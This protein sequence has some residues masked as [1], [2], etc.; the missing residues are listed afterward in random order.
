MPIT[1]AVHGVL[2]EGKEVIATLTELMT[3]KLKGEV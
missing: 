2:F 3:R 1:E